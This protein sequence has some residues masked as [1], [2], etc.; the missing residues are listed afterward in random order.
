[1]ISKVL[2]KVS[3]HPFVSENV[4]QGFRNGVCGFQIGVQEL[5]FLR[6]PF[7]YKRRNKV[8]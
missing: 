5:R 7:A 8:F 1:M 4:V 3:F 6:K 2:E